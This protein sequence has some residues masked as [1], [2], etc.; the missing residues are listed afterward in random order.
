MRRLLYIS[1]GHQP[2]DFYE[3]FKKH[4]EVSLYQ[5]VDH[6]I[7]F[8][9]DH[10]HMHAGAID[11]ESLKM[12]G[13][14]VGYDD[15]YSPTITQ[16][17]GDAGVEPLEPIFRCEGLID[18][19]LL[20]A[21]D[22]RYSNVGR[23]EWMPEAIKANQV[24][25]IRQDVSRIVF[26]GNFY[27]HLPQGGVR[28]NLC[29][30]LTRKYKQFEVYG[31]FPTESTNC[32]GSIPYEQSHKKYNDSYIGIAQDNFNIDG[33]FSHRY[34]GIMANTLCL[35]RRFKGAERFFKDGENIVFWDTVDELLEKCDYYINHPSERLRIA[36]NGQELVKNNY[37]YS[38][39]VE[40]YK[41]LVL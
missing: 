37:L 7:R 12:I 14:D 28:L 3:E 41:K 15:Y 22:G 6:A 1:L 13:R 19:T 21:N 8:N 38:H 18:I 29:Q 30:Q 39:W 25:E 4:F 24:N 35:G 32:N 9:P 2:D 20:T 36:K 33:Y 26:I 10:I 16:F 5:G 23:I 31:C 34:L 17:T 40:R 11:F 27:D